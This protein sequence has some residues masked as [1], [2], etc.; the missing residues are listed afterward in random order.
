MIVYVAVDVATLFDDEVGGGVA[1]EVKG[2]QRQ[3]V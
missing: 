1:V 3:S 2:S